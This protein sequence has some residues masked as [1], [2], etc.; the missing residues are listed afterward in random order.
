[1]SKDQQLCQLFG[2]SLMEHLDTVIFRIHHIRAENPDSGRAM[3][4]ILGKRPILQGFAFLAAGRQGLLTQDI[5]AHRPS[6]KERP[7]CP[8]PCRAK[9]GAPRTS[10]T[11]KAAGGNADEIRSHRG[12]QS[13]AG[14]SAKG[15]K[16][17]LS[18]SKSKSVQQCYI[19]IC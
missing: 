13:S 14:I 16:P 19:G 9:H 11:P 10:R 12:S 4:K 7:E 1:M 15:F 18:L 3:A 5:L 17:R 2:I 8:S 6:P